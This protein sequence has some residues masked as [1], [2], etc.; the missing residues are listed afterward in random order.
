MKSCGVCGA[1]PAAPSC[2]PAA[3]AK[4]S[5]YRLDTTNRCPADVKL[6][7]EDCKAYACRIGA[8]FHTETKVYDTPQ[9]C[10][11]YHGTEVYY[12][13]AAV[14]TWSSDQTREVK[15][16]V[17]SCNTERECVCGSHREHAAIAKN[18]RGACPDQSR[19]GQTSC[20]KIKANGW[21]D[22]NGL[23]PSWA[24]N[25]E[26]CM[27]SCR[28]ASYNPVCT[29]GNSAD[30]GDQTL[31]CSKYEGVSN[32]PWACYKVDPKSLL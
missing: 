6:S 32:Y 10:Y 25:R 19:P 23:S 29:I 30:F 27:T 7:E 31:K 22:P 3:D 17:F 9:G 14:D 5:S 24:T 20:A 26:I 21:C 18:Y 2:K 16:A 4:F 8:G 1:A 11:L 12:N 15:N 13:R 28:D